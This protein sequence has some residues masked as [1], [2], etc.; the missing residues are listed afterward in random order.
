VS[1]IILPG[2]LGA[3]SDID[4]TQSQ[5]RQQITAI[6]EA[7]RQLGGNPEIGAGAVVNDPLNAPYVLYVNPY[8][9]KDTFVGGSFSTSG[10]ATERIELQRLECGYTEAR[11]FRTINRA[12][13]EVGIITAKSYYEKPLG[14]NDLVSI[15]LAP[16]AGSVLNGPGAAT[17]PEWESG[18]EP[19]DAELQ[20]FNPQTVGGILLPRGLSVCGMDLRKTIIRPDVVPSA[21]DEASDYSNRRAIFKLTGVGYFFGF[22][23]MDKVGSTASHHLLD[24]FQFASRTELDAFYTKIRSAFDGT[25]NTG[26]LDP[27]LAVTNA[28]EYEIV[29]PIDI[30]QAPTSAWD[31]TTSASPYIFNCSI[32]SDYGLCGAFMD[33]SK[34]SGLKSMVCANFTGVSL[35]KDMS[36]WQRFNGTTWVQPTYA[37]YISGSPNS[38]RMNPARLSRHIAAINDCFVQEVSVFAIGHGIHH[39]T[40]LGGEITVTN[41]NS[42]VGGCAALSRGYKSYAFPQ[43]ESWTISRIKAPL[44]LSEKPG[45]VRRIYLGVVSAITSTS[46]TLVEQLATDESSTTVPAEL[47]ALGY[48]FPSTTKIWI[49]N[50]AG[51]DWLANLSSSAWS[52][53]TPAQINVQ[54]AFT[55]AGTGTPVGTNSLTSESYAIGRRVYIRRLI[56]TR[57][58]NERRTVLLLNNTTSARTPEKNFVLQTDPARAGGAISR[59]LQPGGS[60]V[61]IATSSGIGATPGAGV[62]RTAEVTIRRGAPTINYATGTYYRAGTVALYQNKHYRSLKDQTTSTSVPDS[63]TWGEAFVHMASAYNAEDGITNEA[64]ILVLDTDTDANT[65]TTTCGINFTTIWTSAGPVRDQYRSSTDYAGIHALLVALGLSA[66]AAHDALVPQVESARERDPASA[67]D[68]PVAPSGGAA[69]GRG[70]WAIEFRRPSI[71]RLYGHA[72]EWAGYLNYS[73]SIP[74]AQQDLAPQNKFT[75]YFT[76]DAGGRVVPQGSNEDGFNITPR[77]LE[78]IE[79]GSTV[80]IDSIGSSTLDES[81]TTDFPNGLTASTIEVDALTINNSVLFPDAVDFPGT[82]TITPGGIR[83]ATFDENRNLI[84]GSTVGRNNGRLQIEGIDSTGSASFSLFCNSIPTGDDADY[85]GLFL[86]RSRGTELGSYDLVVEGDRLGIYRFSGTDGVKLL[87]GVDIQCIVDGATSLGNLPARLAFYVCPGPSTGLETVEALRITSDR[88]VA[89][90]Q[91][92]PISIAAAATLTIADL[93]NGIIEYTGASATL[94]LPTG[95]LSEAGFSGIYTGM[96]FEWSVIHT[97]SSGNCTIAAGAAHTIVGHATVAHGTS[98]RFATRRT[99]ANTFVSYR[100]GS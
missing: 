75:Y 20:A 83:A 14:N 15:V 3:I 99:A 96:T 27:V 13:I 64:P 28:P 33:G 25:N 74:A 57:T 12:I 16:G 91:D 41:S 62:S 85:P 55:Q 36:S 71:L 67:V 17:V 100:L 18:K 63:T 45:N 39:F 61:L 98:G 68:F 78:D 97:G 40:D 90:S 76:H 31:T 79:T 7:V 50:P 95:T 43:D 4:T 65:V 11:P 84:L 48:S 35:Q 56:D 80:A 72:W 53:T 94:T 54:A 58:P 1:S 60:E 22:T 38:I 81:Q 92:A 8:T 47:L 32:R 87:S 26:G 59:V 37:E 49:E 77:G 6:T 70:N 51:G 29:G 73:K 89:Y 21:A 86:G 30:T 2:S 52:A 19:T 10:S 82:V 46:I 42:S 93:K 5:F 24:C 88:V 34:V 66:S 23:F 44:N 9:G 69:T